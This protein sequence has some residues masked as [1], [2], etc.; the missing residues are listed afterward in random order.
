MNVLLWIVAGLCGLNI[1]AAMY[2]AGQK[3]VVKYTGTGAVISLVISLV[4]NG[5]VITVCAIAA[6]K[7]VTT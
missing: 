6:T 4:I 3:K 2:S 1:L 7:G 5:F